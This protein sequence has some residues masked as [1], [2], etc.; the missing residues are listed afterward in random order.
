[1]EA[2]VE[3]GR[4]RIHYLQE[5]TPATD[6]VISAV[7]S[8]ALPVTDIAAIEAAAAKLGL[9]IEPCEN[10]LFEPMQQGVGST[11]RVCTKHVLGIDLVIRSL[12]SDP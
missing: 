12:E 7:Q 4:V 8:L 2:V 1:M 10:N 11:K 6:S 9:S 3:L 5:T